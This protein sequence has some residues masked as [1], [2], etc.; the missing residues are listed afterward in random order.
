MKGFDHP[1]ISPW[2]VLAEADIA[3]ANWICRSSDATPELFG[4]ACFH[5]QQAAEKSLKGLLA[6]TDTSIPRTH[7]LMVLAAAL[8][9]PMREAAPVEALADLAEYGVMPRYPTV[10]LALSRKHAERA[11][12]DATAVLDWSR[13]RLAAT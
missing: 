10:G 1:S 12:A 5:A 2:F 11:L 8:Q 4:L 7:D 13:R 3:V 6:A 9:A